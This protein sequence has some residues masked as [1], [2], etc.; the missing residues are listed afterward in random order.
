MS[1]SII[2]ASSAALKCRQRKKAWLAQLNAKVEFLSQENERLTSALVSSREEIARLGALVG[3][4]GV[5]GAL[6]GH[7]I[8]NGVNGMQ[9]GGLS[10][11]YSNGGPMP[12]SASTNASALPVSQ[13]L[14]VSLG[15]GKESAPVGHKP[16]AYGY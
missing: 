10:N 6:N 5:A 7:N 1:D 9:Q 14:S 4:A 13:S 8:G 2:H 12:L 11:G 16:G 15:K 3:A